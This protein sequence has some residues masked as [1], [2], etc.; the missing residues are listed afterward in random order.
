M[1]LKIFIVV[2][3]II[4]V[5]LIC[6]VHI[7]KLRLDIVNAGFVNELLTNVSTQSCQIFS[8]ADLLGLPASVQKYFTHV[9]S[10]GQPHIQTIRLQQSGDFRLG[11]MKAPWKQL[12]ARQYFTVNPSGFIWDAMI[13]A[14]PLVHVRVVDMFMAGEG[15][16]RAKIL[17]CVPVVD[18]KPGPEMNSGELMRYLAEAVWFPTAL[19]PTGGVDWTPIDEQSAKATLEHCGTT[20]SLMFY[21]NSRNEVERVFAEDRYREVDGLFEPTPWTGHFSNYQV[22]NDMLIPIDAEVEW[23][24]PE[25]DLI[26]WRGH[27][28]KIEHQWDQSDG[29]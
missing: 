27:L 10:E 7:S 12:N 29:L 24:L 14:N 2:L 25:G 5:G 3:G 16:L 1:W 11:D 28:E 17:S 23:N 15:S 9:L 21:F 19:L 6:V 8:K 18:A 13:K 22:R 4:I 20:V 26:Y